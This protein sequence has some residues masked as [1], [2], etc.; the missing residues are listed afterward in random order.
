[1]AG[2]IKASYTYCHQVARRAARNF[3]YGFLL[4][5]RPKRMALCAAYAYMRRIDDLADTPGAVETKRRLLR[6]WRDLTE[7]AM[8]G[9]PGDEPLWPALID[10]VERYRIPPRYLLDVVVGAEMD[11][12]NTDYH[13]FTELRRYCYHVAGA[14]GLVCLYVFGF[15]DL[16]A[17]E[18]A[19][20]MGIAF[21]LTNILRD[22][23]Q[24]CRMGRVYLPEEDFQRFGCDPR[25]L[26]RNSA[27]AGSLSEML[28]FEA[29]RAWEF[30]RQAWALVPLVS[31][32]SRGAL[33]ALA[34]I[35][36]GL[37]E[38][39]ERR[40]FDVFSARA[41]LSMAEKI[42]ILLWARLGPAGSYE[43]RQRDRSW[44]GLGWAL[45]RHRAR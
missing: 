23:G 26:A 45:L 40:Q 39:I 2:P 7:R 35:Y 12:E 17:P 28:R 13:T 27:P 18:L 37:L 42:A 1:M 25:D 3:Y 10:T 34:R 16:R 30:Y 32:D 4:L 21:Q 20:Q 22:I 19:E 41:R 43:F 15:S 6:E 24:D 29:S 5:P 36:S 31:E 8:R 33:W 44:R 38:E 9:E 11:L 14:V